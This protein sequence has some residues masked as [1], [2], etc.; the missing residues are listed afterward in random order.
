[1]LSGWKSV[2]HLCALHVRV[3]HSLLAGR[4]VQSPSTLHATQAPS[5]S[6]TVPFDVAQPWPTGS[7][8]WDGT[9]PVHV[10]VTQSLVAVGRSV[11]S[12]A[13]STAVP[14]TQRG[15]LQS[16]GL[17]T[18]PG[19]L[20]PSSG[21][22]T[23]LPFATSHVSSVQAFLSSHAGRPTPHSTAHFPAAQWPVALPTLHSV[24]SAFFGCV[25]LPSLHSSSVQNSPSSDTFWSSFTTTSTPDLHTVFWQL[26]GICVDAGPSPSASAVCVQTPSAVHSSVVHASLSLH[27]EAAVH[28]ASVFVA[29]PWVDKPQPPKR[30]TR[31]VAK[32]AAATKSRWFFS[33]IG[34]RS[35]SGRAPEGTAGRTSVADLGLPRAEKMCTAAAPERGRG[36]APAPRHGA[37]RSSRGWSGGSPD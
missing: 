37:R 23:H 18:T 4:F 16:P 2:P 35:F 24:D 34:A 25:G 30:A 3:W 5:P 33:N 15:V 28:R 21:A 10:G 11:S 7:A 9:P 1:M 32:R 26:P 12:T 14:P 20:M 17:S 19:I 22:N 36:S 27:C 31:L 8:G 6:H 13:V 29:V